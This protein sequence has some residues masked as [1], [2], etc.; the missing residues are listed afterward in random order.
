MGLAIV[1]GIVTR[2]GGEIVA[3]SEFGKGST[4]QV[5]LP[6][7]EN[8]S[9]PP[10]EEIIPVK[11]GDERILF[12]DDEVLLSELGKQLLEK[13]GY[14]VEAFTS[15]LEALD[16][17]RSRPGEFDLIITDQ[18]MPGMTGL[19]ITAEIRKL[20]PRIPVILCTGFSESVDEGNF[21][22]KGVDSYIVKPIVKREISRII[23]EVLDSR[24]N[25]I[26]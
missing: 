15:S 24:I 7:T 16:T 11:G 19:Q 14:C 20:N 6:V 2:H 18:T 10:V 23:R 3:R 13:L 26:G 21:K 25:E 17:F 12:L 22:D 8:G 5:F 9:Q 1:H 4:F